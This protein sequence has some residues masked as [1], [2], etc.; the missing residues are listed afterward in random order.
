MREVDKIFEDLR[1]RAARAKAKLVDNPH[2]RY[3]RARRDNPDLAEWE[4]RCLSVVI[5]AKW[6]HA[7]G[8][9]CHAKCAV[10]SGRCHKSATNGNLCGQHWRMA[11]GHEWQFSNHVGAEGKIEWDGICCACR[12]SRAT[13]GVEC[14]CPAKSYKR[15]APFG[16]YSPDCQHCN[17]KQNGFGRD[18]MQRFL[19]AD[20]GKSWQYKATTKTQEKRLAIRAALQIPGSTIRSVMRELH[21]AKN[22]VEMEIK[23]SGRAACECG[24]KAGHK[25]WCAF[26]YA[27]S[28]ARQEFIREWTKP[29]GR[30]T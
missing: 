3:Y 14:K 17:S 19:C 25:G 7:N 1:R 13:P 2:Q 5:K 20:C 22:T 8:T 30:N 23:S 15:L 28:A 6:P 4:I 27:K 18:G 16:T 12:G 21:V 10:Y 26:R 24:G 9:R 11:F 29:K